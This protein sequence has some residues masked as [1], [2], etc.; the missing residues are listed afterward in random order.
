MRGHF[1]NLRFQLC[2]EKDK[3]EREMQKKL[4]DLLR[5]PLLHFTNFLAL[6]ITFTLFLIGIAYFQQ[7]LAHGFKCSAKFIG[8]NSQLNASQ[9]AFFLT[10]L[11][12]KNKKHFN[13][14]FCSVLMGRKDSDYIS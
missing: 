11:F 5:V 8:S 10:N 12:I 7:K 9:I 2:K 1:L 6:I 3:F 4:I 14:P 13:I